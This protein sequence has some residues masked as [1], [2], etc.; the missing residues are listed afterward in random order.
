MAGQR[1]RWFQLSLI[2]C[3][4]TMILSGWFLWANVPWVRT[5]G[6]DYITMTRGWPFVYEHKYAPG[7]RHEALA[8]DIATALAV[9]LLLIFC[10]EALIR[11]GTRKNSWLRLHV[12]TKVF[13]LIMLLFSF[14]LNSQP[15]DLRYGGKYIR[16]TGVISYGWPFRVGIQ[17]TVRFTTGNNTDPAIGRSYARGYYLGSLKLIPVTAN[18]T[19]TFIV[20]MFAGSLSESYARR[21]ERRQQE[22]QA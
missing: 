20:M 11:K 10:S 3:I 6:G 9:L 5:Q 4:L 18:L 22:A 17:Q 7:L 19:L 8:A 21:R 2:T 16:R 15:K 13:L 12:G 1:R 14:W